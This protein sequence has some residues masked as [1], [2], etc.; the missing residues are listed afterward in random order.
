MRL[1]RL[2]NDLPGADLIGGDAEVY[3]LCTDSRVAGEGDL[4][5]CYRG[6]KTDS[7]AYAAQAEARGAAAIVCERKT[8]VACP[9]IV[10]KDG[11]EAMSRIAAAFYGHPERGMQIVGITGTNGK[12]TTAHMI[13]SMLE[14]AGIACGLIGT[15][16]ARYADVS[17]SSALTTPDPI[18]LF[19]LL[20]DMARAGVRVAVMEVSAHALALKKELPIRYEVAVF[21]NLTRDHLDFFGDAERY[22]AAK[23][24]LF[25]AER[26]G[27]AVLNADD[28]FSRELIKGGMPY[29]TYGL[30]TPADAFAVIE[31]ETLHGSRALLN[32]NDELCETLIPL[33]GRHN[34]SNALAAACAAR[35]LGVDVQAIAAGLS[36]TYVE[37][38]LEWAGSYRGGDI[39]IDF[40]HTPDGLEKVLSALKELCG[41]R[42]IVVFGCG[43]N[44]DAGKR[45]GMGVAAAKYA[46]IAVLTSD[47][48]RYEDPMDIISEVELGCRFASGRYV[49]SEERD[50]AIRLA[51]EMMERGDIL[52]IAGKG[53]EHYQEIMGIKYDYNDK[54]VVRSILENRK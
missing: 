20:S 1:Q 13:S 43:G 51:A 39:F 50:K 11:R 32:L 9:Q 37:G 29:I 18:C 53:G 35:R 19:S 22:A 27:C 14:E 26:C 3:S 24:S 52:L 23:R 4:F 41:G 31:S 8:E 34:L 38:R 46:D 5:F 54:A 7:H 36:H 15:L 10:V 17:V 21:T 25:A 40:A 49:V 42:L 6:T 30:E 44:R 2:L 28:A 16:G 47:N 45:R 12:T 33:P 48:P